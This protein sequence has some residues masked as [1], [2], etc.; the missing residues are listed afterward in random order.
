MDGYAITGTP[1][2]AFA[3]FG[4]EGVRYVAELD[5][6][7]GFVAFEGPIPVE[8]ATILANVPESEFWWFKVKRLT[9]EAKVKRYVPGPTTETFGLFSSAAFLTLPGI[10]VLMASPIVGDMILAVTRGPVDGAFWSAAAVSYRDVRVND[11][12]LVSA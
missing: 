11:G 1:E 12:E 6:G 9:P 10:S 8:D 2:E 3:A 5:T 7:Q 4:K